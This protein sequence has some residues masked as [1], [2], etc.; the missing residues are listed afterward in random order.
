MSNINVNSL[1][2]LRFD[3]DPPGIAVGCFVA[4][5]PL[6]YSVGDGPSL[7]LGF[8]LAK[9]VSVNPSSVTVLPYVAVGS[10]ISLQEELLESGSPQ[11]PP[12]SAAGPRRRTSLG[13]PG[14]LSQPQRPAPPRGSNA[15][16]FKSRR[17]V[18]HSS[19]QMHDVALPP[20]HYRRRSVTLHPPASEPSAT[21]PPRQLSPYGERERASF[22]R[23]VLALVRRH[24]QAIKE[25]RHVLNKSNFGHHVG[26]CQEDSRIG[27]PAIPHRPQPDAAQPARPR[28]QSQAA[29]E[30]SRASLASS[31]GSSK[32]ASARPFARGSLRKPA[33]PVAQ[34]SFPSEDH[35]QRYNA[36]WLPTAAPNGVASAKSPNISYVVFVPHQPTDPLRVGL[37][38]VGEVADRAASSSVANDLGEI[39]TNPLQQQIIGSCAGHLQEIPRSHVV[40]AKLSVLERAVVFSSN[41]DLANTLETTSPH[42]ADISS[43]TTSPFKAP[44]KMKRRLSR[45]FGTS[46]AGTLESSLRK[47]LPPSSGRAGRPSASPTHPRAMQSP[48]HARRI[49]LVSVLTPWYRPSR[50][51]AEFTASPGES[52][53]MA[54]STLL[55]ALQQCHRSTRWQWMPW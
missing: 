5:P 49:Q 20:Q 34:A 7:G 30:D 19:D 26:G 36:S 33:T 52:P 46:G 22:V 28:R 47:T 55:G 48:E 13:S 17:S 39:L 4:I 43:G 11:T 8:Q 24:F 18:S 9:V 14:S 23:E 35:K 50:L 45:L 32:R 2:T 37:P 38:L 15:S 41:E 53:W 16:P 12:S 1:E 42:V 27:P 51:L 54:I 21:H 29:D 10:N 6:N 40:L 44:S 25:V 3:L 31:G